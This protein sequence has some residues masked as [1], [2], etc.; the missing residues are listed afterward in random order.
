MAEQ[1]RI[2]LTRLNSVRGFKVAQSIKDQIATMANNIREGDTNGTMRAA[3]EAISA[4]RNILRAFLRNAVVDRPEKMSYLTR[5][6]GI[7]RVD[8]CYHEDIVARMESKRRQFEGAVRVETDDDFSVRIATY[9][10]A[11]TSLDEADTE[12]GLRDRLK[13]TRDKFKK[14]ANVNGNSAEEAGRSRA[15]TAAQHELVVTQ[16]NQAADEILALIS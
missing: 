9:N 1:I 12:Q 2:M 4:G 7:R 16:R 6:I 11:I 3:K 10:E 8:K 13:L 15:A 14:T 5:E